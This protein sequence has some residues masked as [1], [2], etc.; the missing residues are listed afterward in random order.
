MGRTFS[1]CFAISPFLIIADYEIPFP[2]AFFVAKSGVVPAFVLVRFRRERKT[3]ASG[4]PC[5]EVEPPSR[6]CSA[7]L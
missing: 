7:Y 2:F 5:A 4:R 6:I 1:P 3:R